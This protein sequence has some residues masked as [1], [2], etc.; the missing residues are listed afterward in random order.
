[1]SI[2]IIFVFFLFTKDQM[3][4]TSTGGHRLL[5]RLGLRPSLSYARASLGKIRDSLSRT[6]VRLELQK[7]Y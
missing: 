7:D 2:V 1:M 3:Q 6:E 5:D 4:Q